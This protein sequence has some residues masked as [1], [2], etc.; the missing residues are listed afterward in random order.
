MTGLCTCSSIH[1]KRQICDDCKWFWHMRCHHWCCHQSSLKFHNKNLNLQNFKIILRNSRLQ[2]ILQS[3][4]ADP[5]LHQYLSLIWKIPQSKDPLLF[6]PPL[7]RELKLLSCCT[8]HTQSGNDETA[9]PAFF[10]VLAKSH[11]ENIFAFAV[12][13]TTRSVITITAFIVSL[14]SELLYWYQLLIFIVNLYKKKL[15]KKL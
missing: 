14:W 10:M 11:F 1:T 4:P 3:P 2:S 7:T 5:T 9:N 13:A 8:K 15:S 12:V 6:G